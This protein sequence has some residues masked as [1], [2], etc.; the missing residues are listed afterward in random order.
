VS[1]LTASVALSLIK[2][3]GTTTLNKLRQQT[4]HQLFT[5]GPGRTYEREWQSYTDKGELYERACEYV[6]CH[7]QR[8]VEIV[9]QSSAMYP[10]A[11]LETPAPPWLLHCN[12]QLSCL[13]NQAVAI[14]GGREA[15]SVGLR[16]ATKLASS[17]V[18]QGLTVVS[19]LARGI[20]G[21]AH[22][23]ALKNTIAVFAGGI[24]TPYPSS[25][26]QL[27]YQIIDRGGLWVSEFGMGVS[28]TPGMFPRRN[29]IVV[30]LS[31]A[32]III[33]A[34]LRSGS[35]VSAQYALDYNRELFAV[36]GNP[37][38]IQNRGC[39]QLIREGAR[40]IT[41]VDELLCDL[42]ITANSVKP[43]V[44]AVSPL[45]QALTGDPKS[46]HQLAS[47]VDQDLIKTLDQLDRLV[48]S[49]IVIREL[50]LYKLANP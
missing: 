32:V 19:G 10:K 4:G 11:L 2:G 44:Q 13:D 38:L 42:T 40:L 23:G 49:G 16:Q 36:P 50:T 33:E 22:R 8:S 46:V 28:P 17:L 25:N 39:H 43:D 3:L 1:T 47:M 6:D 45:V 31:R 20:D 9:D 26:S 18:D 15:T 37:E 35:L 21:A 5:D 48:N 14:V 29:R 41:D 34:A 27:A 30:G 7:N 24:D 12:G